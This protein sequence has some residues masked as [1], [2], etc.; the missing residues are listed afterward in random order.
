MNIR[1]T[2]HPLRCGRSRSGGGSSLPFGSVWEE[3]PRLDGTLL[4]FT[5]Q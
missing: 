5:R 3:H 4:L 2:E 1:Q